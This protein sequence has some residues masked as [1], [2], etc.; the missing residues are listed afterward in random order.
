MAACP[1]AR[2]Y[3]GPWGHPTYTTGM[4]KARGHGVNACL[5]SLGATAC[6]IF[7]ARQSGLV[8]WNLTIEWHLG[9]PLEK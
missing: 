1:G 4:G 5:H 2:W 3:R 8:L 7:P 9:H 6:L